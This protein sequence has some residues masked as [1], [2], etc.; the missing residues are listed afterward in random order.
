MIQQVT[1]T[2]SYVLISP[3]FKNV[4]HVGSM[5]PEAQ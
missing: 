5:P 2:C 3:G 4:D 1:V